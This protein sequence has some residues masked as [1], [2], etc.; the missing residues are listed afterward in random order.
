MAKHGKPITLSKSKFVAGLQCLKRL[1]WLVHEP[2][3][4]PEPDEE[5]K[6]RF[7]QGHEV[8]VLAQKAFLGGVLVEAEYWEV[9][10]ALE[11]TRELMADPKVPAIFEAA[12]LADRILVRTDILERV[13]GGR[14]R[15]SE[16]KSSTDVREK[17][18]H[19]EDVAIQKYVLERAGVE[20][21]SANLMHL[22][23]SYIFDGVHLVPEKLFTT[24]N[25][26]RKLGEVEKVLPRLLRQQ[27]EALSQN[28][29]PDVE[30][31]DQCECPYKC[32]FFDRCNKELPN[33]H[34]SKLPRIRQAKLDQLAAM[35][36]A[37][38]RDI[39]DDFPLS[40]TQR[41]VCQCAQTGKPYFSA[42]LQTDLETLE[43]P[44][45]FMDFET[46]YPAIPRYA[47]MRP[48]DHIP[49]QWSVHVQRKPGSKLEHHEFLADD[50]RDPRQ[51]FIESLLKVLED[52]DGKGHV[53]VY[54]Q[55]FES[56]RLADLAQW[57]PPYAKRIAK[58]Q[59]RLW[60][61]RPVVEHHV[62]HPDF[63]G[64][65]SLKSVLP[66]L[67]PGMTYE[68]MEVAEGGE[69]GLAYNTLVRGGLS[70]SDRR[71]LRE[72]LLAYCGQDTL[73]MVKLVE[74]LRSA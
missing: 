15:L 48:S 67:I 32:E 28:E 49:F 4:K 14:W 29:P 24:V 40:A 16:V 43:Y 73:A 37:S 2:E 26:S 23:R 30:P 56:T 47:G 3:T 7:A 27:W 74:R 45:Y 8:G 50:G 25:L 6:A 18:H 70:A 71:K 57:L 59:K 1:Y 33:D 62:C 44:L 42:A 31:G 53:V 51:E 19:V 34:M 69:A 11:R 64:S 41:R 68:G 20:L 13:R 65:F 39:P 35:G 54:N 21:S 38:M 46:L 55:S 12:F 5:T 52:A 58:V 72:A 36:I 61:L 60:D 9:G 22:N 10:K 66:A 63:G 17:Y